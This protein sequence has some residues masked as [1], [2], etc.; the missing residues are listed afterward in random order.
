[1]CFSL[2]FR[3]LQEL[4][5]QDGGLILEEKYSKTR[6]KKFKLQKI[7]ELIFLVVSIW[8]ALQIS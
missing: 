3:E 2:E 6:C 4:L 1:M 7:L 8:F 5:D